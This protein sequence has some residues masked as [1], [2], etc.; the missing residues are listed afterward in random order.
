MNVQKYFEVGCLGRAVGW[1]LA[2]LYYFCGQAWG[3]GFMVMENSV[4]E[5]GQAFSG[6]STNID[7]ASAVFFNPGA[8]G[9]LRGSLLSVA[10]YVAIPATEFHDGGSRL[11]PQ[12]GGAALLGGNG[13]DG[14]VTTLIPNLYA[15]H[16]LTERFVLGL[17]VNTPFGVHSS[18]EP[19]WQ[20]R[21]QALDSEIRTVNINPSLAARINDQLSFGAGL[22][23]QYLDTQ[24][25]NALDFG[26]VCLGTLGPSV[27]AP[28][29]LLP[30]QADGRLK[31][32]GNSVGVGYNL[33]ILY[34]PSPNTRMGVSYRSGIH[35]NIAGDADYTVP[36]AALP[37]TRGGQFVDS[38][39]HAPLSLP[40]TVAFGFYQRLDPRWAVTVDALWTHWNL[41]R[42]LDI[43]FA[44]A[45]P[46]SV[47]PLDW[48]DTWR[49]A[50][51]VNYAFGPGTTF[52]L[53][54]AYDQTPIPNAQ[55][56]IPRIP[57]S[58]RVWLA[59]GLSVAPVENLTLHGGYAHLFFQDAPV[60][61]TGPTGDRLV[62]RFS[63]QID[64]V[65]LQF[66]WRF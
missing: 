46:D 36:A 7:D 12:L 6:A 14:G 1:V 40:D 5:M 43:R 37:L 61:T 49:A 26:S 11:V 24:L 35:H 34:A 25:S 8:M 17:G 66:D 33:G 32:E 45:Q 58:D 44:S 29:G 4:K 16:E 19:G 22:D 54:V 51:G 31:L 18:Y 23:V 55:R 10:G 38:R 53:G 42:S 2:L 41:I 39:I 21:Y 13:G 9:R 62:G 50:V 65:G 52:R 60:D 15:A 28:R 57:D 3:A 30:Q 63:N 56:R 27:C 59:A 47:R 20:G 48:Q 64:I